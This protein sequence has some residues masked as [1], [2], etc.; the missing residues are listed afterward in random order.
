MYRDT[1][2]GL[3]CW[4]LCSLALVCIGAH[5]APAAV[6]GLIVS[7]ALWGRDKAS[8]QQGVSRP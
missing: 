2:H 5:W 7:L 3:M 6:V 1:A 4:A 8:A